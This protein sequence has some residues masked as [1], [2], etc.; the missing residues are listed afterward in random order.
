M[1]EWVGDVKRIVDGLGG[2]IN[3]NETRVKVAKDII[4]VLREND[5][6]AFVNCG[7]SVNTDDV[8]NNGEFRAEVDTGEIVFTFKYIRGN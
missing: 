2:L 3:D 1:Y 8:I 6:A 4:A 5:V 7:R